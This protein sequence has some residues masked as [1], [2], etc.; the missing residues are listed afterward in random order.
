M[1]EDLLSDLKEKEDELETLLEGARLKAAAIKEEALEKARKLKEAKATE[2]DEE[3]AAMAVERDAAIKEEVERIEREGAS[4]LA[5]LR[6]VCEKNIDRAV[7]EV[8]NFVIGH[9]G[10]AP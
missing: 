2:L 1:P 8:L 9:D 4:A 5:E 3:L 7:E 6:S 10:E